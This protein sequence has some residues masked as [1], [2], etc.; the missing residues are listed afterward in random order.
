MFGPKFLEIFLAGRL[1]G[2]FWLSLV[3]EVIETSNLDQIYPYINS[4]VVGPKVLK[5]ILAGR[6]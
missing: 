1:K 4:W 2:Q 5:I 3:L 6:L